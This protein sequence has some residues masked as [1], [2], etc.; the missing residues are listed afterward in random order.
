[1]DL[2]LTNNSDIIN[3]Y[4]TI[5]NKKFSDHFTIKIWLN[6]SYNQETKEK[7]EY[8]YSTK[9]MQ[10]EYLDADDE[11]WL[12]F[13]AL[14]GRIDIEEETNEMDTKE[15]LDKFYKIL[16]EVVEQVFKK[17][18]EFQDGPREEESEK[19]PRN[20]IPK[21]IRQLMRKKKK[22][23]GK[24]EASRKWWKTFEMM[25]EMEIIETELDDEYKKRAMK[26]ENGAIEKI[27]KNPKFFYSYAK[28]KS[29]SPNQVGPSLK[30]DGSTTK[31]AKE[32]AETLRIQYETMFSKPDLQWKVEDPNVFFEL[33]HETLL[34]MTKALEEDNEEDEA[35]DV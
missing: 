30:P 2:V 16:E 33:D 35:P 6:I 15:K 34:Q 22:L 18:K 23:S 25:E 31:D 28:K 29:K 20:Y 1:M 26:E 5:V 21:K 8:P 3:T 12:R 24:I 10:Y 7:K 19:K 13:D 11:D 32:K 9:L 4:T 27:K 17:K 14:L